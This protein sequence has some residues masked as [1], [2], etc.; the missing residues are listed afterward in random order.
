MYLG[1]TPAGDLIYT[2]YDRDEVRAVRYYPPNA[3]PNPVLQATPSFGQL[4][5]TVNFDASKSTDSNGDDLTFAWDLDG[6]GQYD[7][8]TAAKPSRTYTQAGNVTVRLRVTDDANPPA[9]R[10]RRRSSRPARGR[11][12]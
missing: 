2:D 4:P 3:A 5:L 8:S 11:R 7:D 9:A 6:D 10:R 12:S 1:I